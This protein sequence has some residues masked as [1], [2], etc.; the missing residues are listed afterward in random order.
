MSKYT[1]FA[2]IGAGIIGGPIVNALLSNGASV[3]VITR[4]GSSTASKLPTG[5]KSAVVDLKSASALAAAF[6]EHN[7]EV[8]VSTIGHPGLP[9]QPILADAAKLAGVKLFVPSEFGYSTLGQTEGELGLKDKFAK[10]LVEIGLPSLRIFVGG[11]I[12]FLPWLTEIDSGKF[13]ILGK[14]DSKASFTAAEDI[15][16]FTAHVLTTLPPS[17]LNNAI[18]RIEGT[19]KT[20]REV[21]ALYGDAFPVEQVD[22]FPDEFRTWL[23]RFIES[24]QGTTGGS[25]NDL[26]EGHHWK[27]ITEALKITPESLSTIRSSYP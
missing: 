14:G 24:G 10:Y 23:H 13:R 9:D 4:P 17:Q 5:A 16:G 26:W 12:D 18:F 6:R 11:F 1:S 7:I 3:V 8:V 15:A 19:Q 21:A 27:G 2:V 25:S 20:L 22:T